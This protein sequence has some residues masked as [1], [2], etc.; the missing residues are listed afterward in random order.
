MPG[1]ATSAAQRRAV[2]T[3]TL[4]RYVAIIAAAEALERLLTLHDG[5]STPADF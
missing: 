3:G 1:K 2:R 5:T 4:L